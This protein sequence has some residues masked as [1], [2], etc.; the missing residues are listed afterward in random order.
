MNYKNQ[1]IFLIGFS[2]ATNN[3]GRGNPVGYDGAIN[4][5]VVVRVSGRIQ[6]KFDPRMACYNGSETGKIFFHFNGF[7]ISFLVSD[8]LC[9]PRVGPDGSFL[10]FFFLDRWG[11]RLLCPGICNLVKLCVR[12][13][14]LLWEIFF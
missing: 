11:F 9:R 14:F 4:A 7:R 12:Q 13:G 5:V 8:R 1:E 6:G 3:D 10:N 2:P